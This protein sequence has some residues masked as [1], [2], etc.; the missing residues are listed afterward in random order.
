MPGLRIDAKLAGPP[1]TL[2]QSL[3]R[4]HRGESYYLMR[5]L[6]RSRAP[7]IVKLLLLLLRTKETSLSQFL[8]LGTKLIEEK[9]HDA[10]GHHPDLHGSPLNLLATAVVP[11][12]MR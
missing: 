7:K 8:W 4:R 12:R 5:V 10:Y 9:K 6:P 1:P 2:S 3:G 11:S